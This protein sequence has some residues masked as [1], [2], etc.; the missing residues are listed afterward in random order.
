MINIKSKKANNPSFIKDGNNTHS[1]D[2]SISNFFSNYK[3]L[4][5]RKYVG[6]KSHQDYLQNALP[7]SSVIRECDRL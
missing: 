7:N 4:K 1:D 6:K 2:I 3:L 5:D